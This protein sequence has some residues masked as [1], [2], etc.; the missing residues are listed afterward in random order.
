ML[1]STLC[2]QPHQEHKDMLWGNARFGWSHLQW[3]N[4]SK[5]I[6][7]LSFYLPPKSL[8]ATGGLTENITI[9]Y[10]SCWY[11]EHPECLNKTECIGVAIKWLFSVGVKYDPKCFPPTAAAAAMVIKVCGDRGISTARGPGESPTYRWFSFRR[12]SLNAWKQV[13]S[14]CFPLLLFE[15]CWVM[16]P[17]AI[18]CRAHL[19]W[20]RQI[21][22]E[23]LSWIWGN[24]VCVCVCVCACACV[25]RII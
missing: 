18:G 24:C 4:C 15:P 7:Y 14:V 19:I 9:R 25:S 6:S 8:T 13:V 12:K 3:N 5:P 20:P 16:L 1:V 10:E 21:P 22:G 2:C 23:T 17:A 11:N